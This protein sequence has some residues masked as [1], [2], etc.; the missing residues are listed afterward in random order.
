[1]PIVEK[2]APGSFCWIELATSDQKAAQNFYSTLFGWTANDTPMGPGDFYTIFQLEGR[3]VA[4]GY[5]LRKEQRAQGVPSHWMLYV[6]VDHAEKAAGKVEQAGGKV[7]VPPFDVASYGKMAVIQDPTGPMF[8]IW[9]PK[10]NKGTGMAGVG[11]T[12]CWADLSTPDPA[13]AG[14]FYSEVFGW[15]ISSDTDDHPPS[16]Y[17]HIQNG[18]EFIGGILPN[19]ESDSK[20]P[21]H[22]LAY[23]LVSNCDLS[24]TKAKELGGSFLM[25]P[26]TLEGVGRFAV[27]ADPQSAVFAVFQPLP[28]KK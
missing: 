26:T 21:P 8:S 13:R 10:G 24:A 9:E 15:K 20:V 11:G 23:F 7:L 25:A 22:W 14:K 6:A 4:A 27:I 16:G 19:A 2:H 17:Q 12:L 3:D 18:E 28:R 5:S 1:M